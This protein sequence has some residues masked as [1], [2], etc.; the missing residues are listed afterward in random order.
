MDLKTL[1]YLCAHIGTLLPAFQKLHVYD[2]VHG[3]RRAQVNNGRYTVDVPCNMPVCTVDAAKLASAWGVCDGDPTFRVT[4]ASLMVLGLARRSRLG[5]SDPTAYPRTSPTPITSHTAPGV[6][7]LIEQL[8]PFVAT[9][10]SKIWANGICLHNGFAYATNNVILCR[11]PFP[12]VLP[13][14]VIVPSACFDAVVML[15]EP[16]DMGVEENSVTFY[17][18]E[19]VWVKTLL[20]A[21]SWPTGTVDD[22]V[23]QLNEAKWSTPHSLLAGVLQAAVTLADARIPIV[24]FREGGLRLLDET[25]EADDLEL[26]TAGR[27]NARMATLVFEH[28]TAIQWHTPKQDAHAFKVGEVIGLFGGQR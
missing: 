11:V 18:E 2:N 28:A 3:E 9:D 1:K 6:S 23:N 17:F 16:V 12:T 24:E 21:G 22:Y 15:G 8:R 14:T 25:F 5:L 4:D 10:S 26:P 20:I 13:A 19:D 27:L 7:A